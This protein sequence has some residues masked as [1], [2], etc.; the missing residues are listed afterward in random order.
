L[1]EIH[2][3][4][5]PDGT[6]ILHALDPADW[7]RDPTAGP[8]H[9]RELAGRQAGETVDRLYAPEEIAALL[10]PHFVV[11]SRELVHTRHDYGLSAEWVYVVRPLY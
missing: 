4:L 9:R 6:A 8:P 2:R 3:V 1:S 10:E 5:P 7:R 11:V